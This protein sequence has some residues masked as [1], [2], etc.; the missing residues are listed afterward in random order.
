MIILPGIKPFNI[1]RLYGMYKMSWKYNNNHLITEC[2]ECKKRYSV[3]SAIIVKEEYPFG[4]FRAG[5]WMLNKV[6][7]LFNN[8]TGAWIWV[9]LWVIRN[10]WIDYYPE[11]LI[12]IEYPL[13]ESS[14]IPGYS[15]ISY[16]GIFHI[17]IPTSSLLTGSKILSSILN[18]IFSLSLSLSSIP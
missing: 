15:C 12:W 7:K 14:S 2:N 11:R 5:T 8:Q 18:L 1:E 10:F 3:I 16:K 6:F 17:N 4:E 9:Y 13:L